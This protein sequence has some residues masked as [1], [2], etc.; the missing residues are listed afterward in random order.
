MLEKDDLEVS[1]KGLLK[2]FYKFHT[3][4]AT[5]QDAYDQAVAQ[6]ESEG[7]SCRYKSFDGFRRHQ[8][9]KRKRE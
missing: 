2:L 8:F 3:G 7:Y 9:R 1:K 5:M 4:K 6:A